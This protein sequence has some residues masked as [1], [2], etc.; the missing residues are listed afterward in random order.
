MQPSA[1][2]LPF[3]GGACVWA[4]RISFNY[5]P[6]EVHNFGQMA[7]KQIRHHWR[8][9]RCNFLRPLPFNHAVPCYAM[10]HRAAQVRLT[11]G[12]NATNSVIPWPEAWKADLTPPQPGAKQC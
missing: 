9:L 7:Q 11:K 2:A 3:A 10:L 1:L 6:F 12:K 8:L 4:H 5:M